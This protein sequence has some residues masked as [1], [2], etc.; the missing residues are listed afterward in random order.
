MLIILKHEAPNLFTAKQKTKSTGKKQSDRSISYETVFVT[1]D[2]RRVPV[3]ATINYVAFEGREFSCGFA[4]DITERVRAGQRERQDAQRTE[5]LL[6]LHQRSP[7]MSD[8][9]LY[10]YV[11]DKAVVLTGS[12]IGFFHRVSEDQ[13]AILLTTWNREALNCCTAAFETHYPLGQAGNWVDCVRQQRPVVYNDFAQSPNQKGLPAGHAPVR[14][15]MSIPVVA[16]GKVRIN[17]SRSRGL[18]RRAS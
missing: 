8:R 1:K 10:D 11:L 9:E 3:E 12:A 5:L 4:R 17:H 13:K 7:R 14:R 2:G 6:E 16:D 18:H 15:F